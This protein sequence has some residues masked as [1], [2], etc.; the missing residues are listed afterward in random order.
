MRH[1]LESKY[2]VTPPEP[3]E[4]T[5]EHHEW[6]KEVKPTRLLEWKDFQD[7]TPTFP[8]TIYWKHPKYGMQKSGVT[9]HLDPTIW[10]FCKW[11]YAD[12]YETAKAQEKRW[13]PLGDGWELTLKTELVTEWSKDNIQL[14]YFFGNWEIKMEGESKI[15][16]SLHESIAYVDTINQLI[17][18]IKPNK[19]QE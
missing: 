15:L 6:L 16:I 10:G 4:G 2:I 1:L 5:P 13:N 8:S 11:R 17:N 14:T 12:K 7:E 9:K 19:T 18:D 3:E